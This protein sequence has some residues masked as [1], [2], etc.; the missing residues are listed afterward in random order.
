MKHMMRKKKRRKKSKYIRVGIF[1]VEDVLPYVFTREKRH[2]LRRLGF[3]YH[4]KE[5]ENASRRRYQV[6][7]NGK[8]ESVL[9]SMGSH[10]YQLYAEKGVICVNCGTIGTYFALERGK[11]DNPNRFHFNLYGKDDRGREIMITKDHIMPRSKGGK[12]KLSNYQPMCLKCNQRKADKVDVKR[13]NGFKG[14]GANNVQL[15]HLHG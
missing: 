14:A 15:P 5:W 11:K 1:A 10:R 9:V 6:C 4:S 7:I 8:T 12:N 2:E 3:N 13:Q